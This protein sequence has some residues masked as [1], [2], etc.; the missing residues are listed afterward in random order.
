[1]VHL[2]VTP[3][4][5]IHSKTL[6]AWEHSVRENYEAYQT[7]IDRTTYHLQ[8]VQ[9]GYAIFGSWFYPAFAQRHQ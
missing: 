3:P 1:M 8:R 2:S 7:E 4:D 5:P 6:E 9:R